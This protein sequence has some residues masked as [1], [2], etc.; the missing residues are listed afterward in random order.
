MAVTRA[1]CPRTPC[2]GH[3][4]AKEQLL[5]L[6]WY[7]KRLVVQRHDLV[8]DAAELVQDFQA[9]LL[10]HARVVEARQPCL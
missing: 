5:T 2:L 3:V 4:A 8:K 6:L 9:L 1:P 10:A 7:P